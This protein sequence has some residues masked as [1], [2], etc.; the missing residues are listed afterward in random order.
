ML[1]MAH[2]DWEYLYRSAILERNNEK[3]IPK[4]LTARTV[5][6]ERLRVVGG[7]GYESEETGVLTEALH[8]LDVLLQQGS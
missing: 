2:A 3:F 7:S 4:A 5:I 1:G 6:D 8:N